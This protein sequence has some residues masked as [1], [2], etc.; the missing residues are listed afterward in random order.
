VNAP[1]ALVVV[2][3]VEP[4]RVSVMVT[5]WPLAGAPSGVVTMPRT[6]V[7]VSCAFDATGA[8]SSTMAANAATE[9]CLNAARVDSINRDLYFIID[10]RFKERAK[11]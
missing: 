3:R 10:P 7:V 4:V 1:L 6:A 8:A 5:D 2:A 9:M 11:A